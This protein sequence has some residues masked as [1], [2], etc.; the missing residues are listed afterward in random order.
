MGPPSL[1][2][3]S[4]DG[5]DQ[6]RYRGIV[7]RH[8]HRCR[9]CDRLRRGIFCIP[10]ES[11][12]HDPSGDGAAPDYGVLGQLLGHR[13]RL[14][15]SLARTCPQHGAYR[16][17]ALSLMGLSPVHCWPG[18]SRRSRCS[19]T[20]LLEFSRNRG[21]SSVMP[22]AYAPRRLRLWA[23]QNDSRRFFRRGKRDSTRMGQHQ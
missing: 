4:L 22:V 2:L 9:C 3:F 20:E 10:S 7:S 23:G 18:V 11:P 1:I 19:V 15:T 12:I 5:E 16:S 17:V 13:C 21:G 14:H 6:R 8:S